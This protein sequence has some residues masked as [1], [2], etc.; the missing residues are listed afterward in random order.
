MLVPVP[1]LRPLTILLIGTILTLT[2][3]SVPL[4]LLHRF[5]FNDGTPRN[6]AGKMYGGTLVNGA[7]IRN[8]EIVFDNIGSNITTGSYLR[9][10]NGLL[11]N[12]AQFTGGN[13]ILTFESW[14]HLGARNIAWNRIFQ[15]GIRSSGCPTIRCF[16]N[17]PDGGICCRACGTGSQSNICLATP[18]FIGLKVHLVYVLNSI[19]SQSYLYFN[20][21]LMGTSVMPTFV[22]AQSDIFAIGA[23]DS[24]SD[25]NPTTDAVIDEF[26]IW[27]GELTSS[28]V[29]L[30]SELGPDNP[31][32]S[33]LPHF[34]NFF[35]TVLV[36]L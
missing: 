15:L 6:I 30:N 17:N 10:P 9:V 1:F 7:Y 28:M 19:T 13:G 20:G 18:Q 24:T 26:R 12:T 4:V 8:Q 31:I 2:S 34:F 11:W 27:R 25:I 22:F 14:I 33:R 32:N 23:Q 3:S 21:T 29:S 5:S 36:C 16:R 35:L